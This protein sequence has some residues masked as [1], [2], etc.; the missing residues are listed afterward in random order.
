MIFSKVR[1]VTSYQ[2]SLASCYLLN[3]WNQW[4]VLEKLFVFYVY[5]LQVNYKA[6]NILQ[7]VTSCKLE[8]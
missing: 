3:H 1:P 2:L 7:I 4:N 6:Q 5:N 8:I